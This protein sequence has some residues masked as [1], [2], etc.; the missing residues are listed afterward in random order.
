V[1][2][3]LEPVPMK[4]GM[5]AFSVTDAGGTSGGTAHHR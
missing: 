2:M 4:V 3:S 5:L 1:M